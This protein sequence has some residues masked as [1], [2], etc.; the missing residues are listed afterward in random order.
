MIKA[1][2]ASDVCH[3]IATTSIF[4]ETTERLLEENKGMLSRREGG[5]GVDHKIMKEI[6]MG[7]VY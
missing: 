5:E 4:I 3:V 7:S 6:K 2:V 1:I